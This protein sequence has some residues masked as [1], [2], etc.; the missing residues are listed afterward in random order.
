MNA[1]QLKINISVTLYEA[2]ARGSYSKYSSMLNKA[3]LNMYCFVRTLK[4][5][6]A[7]WDS[8]LTLLYKTPQYELWSFGV[9]R[10]IVKN[11]VSLPVPEMG[12][13]YNRVHKNATHKGAIIGG[14]KICHV[15]GVSFLFWMGCLM[16]DLW[17][18]NAFQIV[19]FL[20]PTIFVKA[21]QMNETWCVL[22]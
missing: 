9:S 18:C 3:N 1:L 16:L 12:Q 13:E 2:Y 8:I 14:G 19:A 10:F 22:P 5:M 20:N 6:R 7:L 4:L 21:L 11:V 17:W 15:L